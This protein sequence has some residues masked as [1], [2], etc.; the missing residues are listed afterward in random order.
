[1]IVV[2]CHVISVSD[3]V[4]ETTHFWTLLIQSEN[5]SPDRLGHACAD[6]W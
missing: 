4:S 6:T 2:G 3:S 1:M 5:A